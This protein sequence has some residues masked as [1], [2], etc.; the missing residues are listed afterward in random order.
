M[1]THQVKDNSLPKTAPSLICLLSC[2]LGEFCP[3]SGL[4]KRQSSASVTVLLER[5]GIYKERGKKDSKHL[6]AHGKPRFE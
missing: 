6:F 4:L 5:K 2:S 1:A 3:F